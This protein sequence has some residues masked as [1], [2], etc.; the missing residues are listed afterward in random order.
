MFYR[1]IEETWVTKKA[2]EIRDRRLRRQR[3]PYE[4]VIDLRHSPRLFRGVQLFLSPLGS[5]SALSGLDLFILEAGQGGEGPQ[6]ALGDIR[7]WDRESAFPQ[8]KGK[9]SEGAREKW[10]YRWT[11]CKLRAG[12]PRFSFGC[13]HI[14]RQTRG[15]PCQEGSPARRRANFYLHCK[16]AAGTLFLFSKLKKSIRHENRE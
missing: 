3:R 11:G 16:Y 13:R 4:M 7:L 14:A 9:V 12:V 10:E 2:F 1:G 5:P 8:R 6:G 15:V